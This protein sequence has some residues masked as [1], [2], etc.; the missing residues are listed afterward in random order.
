MSEVPSTSCGTPLALA[1]ADELVRASQLLADLA[2]DLGSDPG[3]LRRHMSSLQ[4]VDL[5]TQIQIAVAE[6]L[7]SPVITPDLLKSVPLEDMAARL[8][9]LGGAGRTP[10]V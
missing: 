4:R 2:F 8:E 3:T 6:L 1:L 9:G 10:A 5:V 7:R